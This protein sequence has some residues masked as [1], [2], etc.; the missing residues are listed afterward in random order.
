L[1]VERLRLDNLATG[2]G[3]VGGVEALVIDQDFEV[4]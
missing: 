3:D 4:V 2:K 1:F